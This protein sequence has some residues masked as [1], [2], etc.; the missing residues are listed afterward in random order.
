MKLLELF[1]REYEKLQI[2][3]DVSNKPVDTLSSVSTSS[4]SSVSVYRRI[5]DKILLCRNAQSSRCFKPLKNGYHSLLD[6]Y[7][8]NRIHYNQISIS[9]NQISISEQFL[10]KTIF[11]KKKIGLSYRIKPSNTNRFINHVFY[12]DKPFDSFTF[13]SNSLGLS[14]NMITVRELLTYSCLGAGLRALVNEVNYPSPVLIEI[15]TYFDGLYGRFF[16]LVT[17]GLGCTVWSAFEP[18][19]SYQLPESEIFSPMVSYDPFFHIYDYNIPNF[20]RFQ[21]LEIKDVFDTILYTYENEYPFSMIEVP[22]NTNSS[23][24][25]TSSSSSSSSSNQDMAVK[26]G[27]MV[28]FLL[29]IGIVPN[30]SNDYSRNIKL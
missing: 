25:S 22:T 16:V 4:S 12:I 13:L 27:V 7:F 23:S 28:A 19:V 24:S 5:M 20:S 17:L 1:N 26:L 6:T 29:A 8:K 15:L 9:D 30:L 11:Y 2:F 18:G 21:F 3:S 10:S 14:C